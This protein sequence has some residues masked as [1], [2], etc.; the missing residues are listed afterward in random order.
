MWHVVKSQNGPLVTIPT[1]HMKGFTKQAK[2]HKKAQA[3]SFFTSC[4]ASGDYL[5]D[6]WEAE[7]TM[8]FVF[9]LSMKIKRTL[10]AWVA[11]GFVRQIL[12]KYSH[13]PNSRDVVRK[14]VQLLFKQ[15]QRGGSAGSWKSPLGHANKTCLSSAC[16]NLSSDDCVLQQNSRNSWLE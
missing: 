15:R 12:R 9:G 5:W 8:S 4:F 7:R 11:F 16:L 10:S 14:I 3:M 1:P 13:T 6:C 2:V